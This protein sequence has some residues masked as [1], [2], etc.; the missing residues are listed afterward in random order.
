MK[1]SVLIVTYNSES[2]IKP[3]LDGV[4]GAKDQIEIIVIDNASVDQTREILQTYPGIK[5][6]FNRKNLGYAKANNQG[7]AI[8]KGDYLLLL[9][10]D[11]IATP[12]SIQL[13]VEYLDR[14]P[15]IAAVA[16]RLLKPD[17]S[18]QLSIRSF[19]TFSSVLGEI[20]GLP[21]LFPKLHR[22]G[23]WRRRDFNYEKPDFVEQPMASCLLIRRSV[24]LQLGGF[25][26]NFPIYYNDVDLSY[27]MFRKGYKTYYLPS[28]RVVHK[29]GGSTNPLKPK[30]IFENHR[31]LFRFLKKHTPK[32]R[33]TFQAIILLPLLEISALLRTLYWRLT[34]HPKTIKRN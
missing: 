26:E 30:M 28:A 2:D 14:N 6:I 11:T 29:I 23:R 33:F 31:A 19:P 7:A 4:I 17:C 9:N 24:F 13:L 16:P 25:D 12:S 1:L 34:H 18:T 5:T 20:T 10:P 27:R 22:L 15:D 32:T 21:R 3:C 8:S